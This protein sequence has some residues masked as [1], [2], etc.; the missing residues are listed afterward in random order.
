MK[1]AY[2]EQECLVL[3]LYKVKDL[4]LLDL[5]YLVYT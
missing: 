1:L 5:G 4:Y 3:T 2:T